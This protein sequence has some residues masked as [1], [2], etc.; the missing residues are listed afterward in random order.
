MSQARPLTQLSFS[1]GSHSP[2]L[3]GKASPGVSYLEIH[4]P[5]LGAD[6]LQVLQVGFPKGVFHQT[7]AGIAGR[8]HL[9]A[10]LMVSD[11]GGAVRPSPGGS[12]HVCSYMEGERISSAAERDQPAPPSRLMV[13][14]GEPTPVAIP[15][16]RGPCSARRGFKQSNETTKGAKSLHSKLLGKPGVQTGEVLSE[17]FAARK[18]LTAFSQTSL[19]KTKGLLMKFH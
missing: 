15:E 14:T 10:R 13:G 4:L 11:L 12:L 16:A 18:S 1:W 17:Q 3:P 9:L 8:G 6:L 2:P 19:E 5:G 7:G